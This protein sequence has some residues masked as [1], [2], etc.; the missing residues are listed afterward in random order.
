MKI[1]YICNIIF[2]KMKVSYASLPVESFLL[3]ISLI[4]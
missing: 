3:T 4:Q 1:L 2:P